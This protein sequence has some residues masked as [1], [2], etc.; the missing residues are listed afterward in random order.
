MKRTII[1]TLMAACALFSGCRRDAITDG[2]FG[3]GEG[4]LSLKVA[5]DGRYI[6][7]ANDEIN[8]FTIT[9]TRPADGWTK[10]FVRF[11]DMPQVL[12]LGSGDYTIVAESPSKEDAAFDQPIYY[13]TAD[14]TI[15]T[16]ELTPVSLTCSLTNMMVT[17]ETSDNFR[18]EL[19]AYTV[20]I[21][22]AAS[23]TAEDAESRTLVWDK[24]AVDANTP[25]Y[26]TV[27]T[28]LVKVDAYRNVDNSET[29]ATMVIRNV[30]AKDHHIINLDAR[31]T[32]Q[33]GGENGG[34]V[35]VIDDTLND[36]DQ[37]VDSPGFD[38]VPVDGGNEGDDESDDPSPV[39]ESE[40]P[41]SS[42]A[43]TMT[44]EANPTFAPTTIADGMDVNILINAP[45]KIAGFVV[46]V[47]SMELAPVIA[48]LGGAADSEVS[49]YD[50]DLINDATMIESLD[51]MG[52]GIPTGDALKGQTEVLFSL[53][54][55][56]PMISLYQP[57]SGA[58]HIFTL[59]VT[60]EA[61]QS[62]VKA[63]TFVSE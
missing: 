43:P 57:E 7:K 20:T 33:L 48:V 11:G 18:N 27:D 62:L 54:A 5:S 24:D 59:T 36:K 9:I 63:L 55:L 30:A 49:E 53:S 14:F 17:F 25:G 28:L 8:N 19:S 52:L 42:T 45:E 22:N 37:N 44:W 29:H 60:D 47:N 1:L 16:G 34:V 51:S 10:E 15:K 21:T 6:T 12:E 50:M 32:G 23:W 40:D 26:F 56:V 13:G 39:E 46:N 58:E 4:G 35:L 2:H 38:E 31:V 41:V 61:G 3:P